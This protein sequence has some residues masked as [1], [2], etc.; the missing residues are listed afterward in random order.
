MAKETIPNTILK[1]GGWPS[2]SFGALTGWFKYDWIAKNTDVHDNNL[3]LMNMAAIGNDWEI[4]PEAA[5]DL[6]FA[7]K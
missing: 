5:S 6:G 7:G 1:S 3:F 2:D 4:M